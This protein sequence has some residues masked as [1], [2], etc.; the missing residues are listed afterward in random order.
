MLNRYG[1]TNDHLGVMEAMDDSDKEGKG[2]NVTA[3]FTLAFTR[4]HDEAEQFL[5]SKHFDNISPLQYFYAVSDSKQI[6]SP[7]PTATYLDSLNLKLVHWQS[8][9]F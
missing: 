5:L 8:F 3:S 6:D 9:H 2:L 7:S 1:T 4:S